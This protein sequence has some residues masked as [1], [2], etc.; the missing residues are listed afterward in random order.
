[1]DLNALNNTLRDGVAFLG[2]LLATLEQQSNVANVHGSISGAVSIVK[3]LQGAAVSFT[4]LLASSDQMLSTSEL[5]D[6]MG[7]LG[8]A[9]ANAAT[10]AANRL[11]LPERERLDH[12][13][14]IVDETVRLF[15]AELEQFHREITERRRQGISALENPKLLED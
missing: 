8:D 6:I 15:T 12:R 7:R 14:L 1:M 13:D 11:D 4:K 5:R 9:C 2:K 3:T 10:V